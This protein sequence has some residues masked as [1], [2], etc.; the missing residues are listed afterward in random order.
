VKILKSNP[1]TLGCPLL[2]DGPTVLTKSEGEKKVTLG[3]IEPKD[4]KRLFPSRNNRFC[5][6]E[7]TGTSISKINKILNIALPQRGR[8][9]L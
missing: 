6:I 5:S 8:M 1:A 2:F 4:K 9:I 7:S 3:S